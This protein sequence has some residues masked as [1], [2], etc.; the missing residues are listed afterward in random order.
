MAIA[1]VI[2][3]GT[4]VVINGADTDDADIIRHNGQTAFVIGEVTNAPEQIFIVRTGDGGEFEAF[5]EELV[6]A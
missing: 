6:A 3:I 5:P 1:T 4:E 2:A